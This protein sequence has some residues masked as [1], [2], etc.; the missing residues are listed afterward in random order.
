MGLDGVAVL[1][2][3]DVANNLPLIYKITPGAL[4]ANLITLPGADEGYINSVAIG[5][6]RTA[7]SGGLGTTIHQPLIYKVASGA[8]NATLITLPG[9]DL[10][11]GA[12]SHFF[13]QTIYPII[14]MG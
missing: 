2:G 10:L 7:I 8:S 9:P 14:Q 3:G 1:A 11:F 5:P 12:G 6:D 13:L 4:N